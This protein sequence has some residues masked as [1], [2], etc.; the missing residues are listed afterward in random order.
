MLSF[1]STEMLYN[2]F[3]QQSSLE[4]STIHIPCME[5]WAVQEKRV[6]SQVPGQ[7]MSSSILACH[8]M[9]CEW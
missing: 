8:H 2:P 6:L 7:R 5:L 1:R 3:V 9:Q 4:S